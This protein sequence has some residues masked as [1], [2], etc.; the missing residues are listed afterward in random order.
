MASAVSYEL[1]QSMK[2]ANGGLATLGNDGLIPLNQLPPTSQSIFL[3]IFATVADLPA[4][5]SMAQF[6]WVTAENM[7]YYYNSKLTT[8]TF[9]PQQIEESDYLLLTSV[10]QS[11]VPY[12]V[13]PDTV[14]P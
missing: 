5:G 4:T 8:P 9:V 10:Q 13:V 2:G 12:V 7:F 6:A 3:G 11:A 14:S 1:L